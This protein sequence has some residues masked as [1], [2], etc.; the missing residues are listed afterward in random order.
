MLTDEQARALGERWIKAG[1][2]VTAG[3]LYFRQT[4]RE[5][6][7]DE[8]SEW[9]EPWPERHDGDQPPKQCR[10]TSR[11]DSDGDTRVLGPDLRDPATKGGGDGGGAGEV[12]RA[13]GVDSANALQP[14]P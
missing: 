4:Y 3:M 14:R 8:P 13:A 2:P 9:G 11:R 7:R 10:L 6:L 1:G 5:G 12:G